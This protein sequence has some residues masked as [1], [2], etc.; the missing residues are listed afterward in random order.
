MDY[1][2]L[3]GVV[4]MISNQQKLQKAMEL[5]IA[6]VVLNNIHNDYTD[7]LKNLDKEMDFY[8]QYP[9]LLTREKMAEVD[10]TMA[11]IKDRQK[12]YMDHSDVLFKE[13]REFFAECGINLEVLDALMKAADPS[14][15]ENEDKPV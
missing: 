11:E 4:T 5:R 13:S 1:I 8:K 12:Y 9:F 14:L 7:K 2:L 10:A 6:F 15:Y 3:K